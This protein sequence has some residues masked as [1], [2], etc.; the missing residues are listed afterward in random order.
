[1]DLTGTPF[2]VLVIVV[3]V[4]LFLAVVLLPWRRGWGSLIARTSAVLGLNAS[5]LLVAALVLNNMFSF[6]VN[7]ADLLGRSAVTTTQVGVSPQGAVARRV[8]G[9]GFRQFRA[10]PASLPRLPKPGG[11]VQTYTYRGPS[12]GVTGQILVYLPASYQERGAQ[13]RTY[14]VI[15]ALH[16][17]P[18]NPIG[19]LKG[20]ALG[21]TADS[22]TS[23]RELGESV[24]VLPQINIPVTE[25]SECVN[26]PRGAP[27]VETWLAH[28]VPQFVISHFRVPHVRSSWTTM[29][30]SE[31]GWCA[32]MLTMLHSDVYGAAVVFGGYFHPEFSSRYQPFAVRSAASRRYD[33]LRLVQHRAPA[34]AMWVETSHKDGVSYTSTAAVLRH[35][36]PPM[37]VTAVVLKNAGHRVS[38]WRDEEPTALKWLGHELRG[39]APR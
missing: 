2:L 15:E 20:M 11:R 10:A 31:G 12:S 30:F 37:S 16:G 26:G 29:G 1:M 7:W 8:A 13:A 34:I 25:D 4:V 36:R 23:S 27:Q 39:F 32:A 38:V 9:P 24:I 5:V 33:L 35:I 14:P 17:Y 19:W 18:G 22:L 3:A 21:S 28:D 6:Y